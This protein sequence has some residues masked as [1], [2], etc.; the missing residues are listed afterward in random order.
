M[1]VDIA[2]L[3]YRNTYL[4]QY[5]M[6]RSFMRR[7]LESASIFNAT[8]EIWAERMVVN[9]LFKPELGIDQL[10]TMFGEMGAC[11]VE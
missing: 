10:H 1:N 5:N 2:A 7:R 9:I 3:G 6:I 11:L 8:K 4:I